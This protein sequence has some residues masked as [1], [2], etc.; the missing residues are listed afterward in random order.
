MRTHTLRKL[1]F[2]YLLSL[3]V[4]LLAA[5]SIAAQ[6]GDSCKQD[7]VDVGFQGT[8]CGIGPFNVTLNGVIASGS[9]TKCMNT[10][11]SNFFFTSTN[12]A[13]AKLKVDQKYIVTSGTGIC[14]N[15]IN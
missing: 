10:V 14:V 9:N 3:S 4:L 11:G 2:T 7:G 6:E 8:V 13:F 12:K 15:H 5:G 1:T